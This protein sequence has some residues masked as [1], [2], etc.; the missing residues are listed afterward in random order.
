MKERLCLARGLLATFAAAIPVVAVAE[1]LT[2]TTNVPPNH[3]ASTEGGVPF[4]QCVTETTKGEV[5]FEYYH[6]AQIA[7]MSEALSAV[8]DGLAQIGMIIPSEQTDKLPLT[9]VV[10]L[11]GMG[12]SVTHM[13]RAYRRSLTE[14]GVLAQELESTGVHPLFLNFHPPYQLLSDVPYES[15]DDLRGKKLRGI[16]SLVITLKSLGATPVEIS[17]PDLYLSLQQGTVDGALLGLTSVQPYSLQEVVG[18][19]TSN[20]HF[21]TTV[22]IWAIDQAIW[23]GLSPEYRAAMEQCGEEVDETQAAYADKLNDELKV[24]FAEQ[25]VN[26]YELNE[27]ALDSFTPGLDAATEE[28]IT[29]LEG[30]GLPA[31]QALKEYSEALAATAQ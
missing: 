14:G 29:R 17:I 30:R 27:K 13:T 16:G 5:E 23:D 25:G 11:P 12:D 8:N 3:W 9:G 7:S 31:R 4:M 26:I 22:G 28:F 20:G 21:G 15:V 6:S 18:A 10:M 24:K 19:M 1:T 2:V